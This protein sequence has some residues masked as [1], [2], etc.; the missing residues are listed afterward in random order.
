MGSKPMFIYMNI[1]DTSDSTKILP[2]LYVP[3]LSD[4]R[5]TWNSRKGY[6]EKGAVNMCNLNLQTFQKAT[7]G[8]AGPDLA[9]GRH[10]TDLFQQYSIQPLPV[11][12][13][14]AKAG[15]W[16]QLKAMV[17]LEISRVNL[18]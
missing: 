4:F 6:D 3:D 13:V 12:G 2:S 16:K 18:E 9:K 11:P 14:L 7:V 5:K 1:P 8:N 15:K 17:H 10:Q